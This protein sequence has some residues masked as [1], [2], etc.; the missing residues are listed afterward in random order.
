M[1]QQGREGCWA[2]S[3]G[4]ARHFGAVRLAGASGHTQRPWCRDPTSRYICEYQRNSKRRAAGCKYLI[5]RHLWLFLTAE[6]INFASLVGRF[7]A[8]SA[9][10]V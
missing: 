3:A 5:V 9:L 10:N 4:G 7:Y 6:V 8:G 2:V 1:A